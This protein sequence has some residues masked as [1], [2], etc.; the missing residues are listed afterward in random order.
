MRLR[1]PSGC[2]DKTL[3]SKCRPKPGNPPSR[4]YLKDYV[5][6]DDSVRVVNVFVEQLD[7]GQLCFEGVNPSATG[8]PAYNPAIRLKLYIYGYLN[9]IHPAAV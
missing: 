4:E 9:R 7:L 8:R 2:A 3:H 1:P 5:A 6:E